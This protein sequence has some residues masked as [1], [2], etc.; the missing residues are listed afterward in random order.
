MHEKEKMQ[1]H[2]LKTTTLGKLSGLKETHL[3]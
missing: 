1:V 2:F 3:R